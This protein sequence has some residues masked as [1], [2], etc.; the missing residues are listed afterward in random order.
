M[1]AIAIPNDPCELTRFIEAHYHA[2]HRKDLP[3]LA[4]L[5]AK[6]EQVH[7]SSPDVPAGL[8]DLLKRMIGELEVH[9]KEEE[10]LLFPAIRKGGVPGLHAPIAVMRGDHD[11]HSADIARIRELT[12]NL[13]PPADACQSWRTLYEE[14]GN[15]I[16]ELDAHIKLE[17]DVLFPRFEA[18]H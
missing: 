8:A 7:A 18:T 13:A 11:D 5:A 14:L 16:G 1:T 17:N 3:R 6:V 10:L 2:R 4:S 12:N 15:F 9:M